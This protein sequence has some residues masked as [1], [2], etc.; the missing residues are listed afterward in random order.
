MYAPLVELDHGVA[1]DEYC[2]CV[3]YLPRRGGPLPAVLQ[4]A[5][6]AVNRHGSLRDAICS[7]EHMGCSSGRLL[8]ILAVVQRGPRRFSLTDRPHHLGPPDDDPPEDDLDLGDVPDDPE[9]TSE[10]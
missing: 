1:P 8:A 2:I 10:G 4:H 5:E 6:A 3:Q 9:A 7:L